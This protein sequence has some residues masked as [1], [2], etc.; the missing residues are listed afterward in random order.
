LQQICSQIVDFKATAS[1]IRD[2]RDTIGHIE[3]LY[4]FTRGSGIAAPQIGE[5]LAVNVLAFE[6]KE[7]VICNPRIVAHSDEMIEV[8]EGCLS[9]FDVRGK[10]PRWAS[11]KVEAENE[12]GVTYII[13]ADNPNF[14]SLLQHE[15]DH[16]AGRLYVDRLP[17]GTELIPKP[18]V[19]AIP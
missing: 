13:E 12:H 18:G 5:S 4:D 8:S 9:F 14:V 3:T 19:P 11:I 1:V 17:A 10:V 16:L 15:I 2:L 6:G 7:Y